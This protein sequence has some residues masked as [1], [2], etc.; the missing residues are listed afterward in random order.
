MTK[1]LR[2]GT[3]RVIL[4]KEIQQKETKKMKFKDAMIMFAIAERLNIKTLGQLSNVKKVFGCE[5]NQEL[6]RTLAGAW[7]ARVN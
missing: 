2:Y 3:I 5:T 6:A 7:T 1:E 4:K